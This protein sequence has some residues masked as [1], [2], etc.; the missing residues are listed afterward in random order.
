MVDKRMKINELYIGRQKTTQ[1]HTSVTSPSRNPANGKDVKDI[2]PTTQ[3]V[4]PVDPNQITAIRKKISTTA[5]SAFKG[6]SLATMLNKMDLN[7]EEPIEPQGSQG[8]QGSIAPGTA[9]TGK[10]DDE[11]NITLS[12]PADPSDE[13][14]FVPAAVVKAQNPYENLQILAGIKK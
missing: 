10:A 1:D 8:P 4:E 3:R 2:S 12:D 7:K 6:T 11:G 9:V 14:V 5:D 13:E